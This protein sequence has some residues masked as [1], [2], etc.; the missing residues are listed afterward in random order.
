MKRIVG[1]A[2]GTGAAAMFI[3][4]IAVA[5]AGSPPDSIEKAVK[6]KANSGNVKVTGSLIPQKVKVQAIGTATTT[7]IR[8][9]DRREID[10]TGRST[11]TQI[12]AE[13]PSIRVFG[14]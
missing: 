6:H 7:P 5:E 11:V 9:Y 4:L 8:V 12:L 13:D 3:G 2:A 1:V 10:R 14:H